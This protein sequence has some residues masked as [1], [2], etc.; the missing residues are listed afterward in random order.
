M[1]SLPMGNDN[2][3]AATT[4]NG[5]GS[6][7]QDKQLHD[8]VALLGE[9]MPHDQ[10]S[11]HY[12]F[13]SNFMSLRL[14]LLKPTPS[15]D[16]LEQRGTLLSS[17]ASYLSSGRSK[18]DIAVMIARDYMFLKQQLRSKPSPRLQA[19]IPN[20]NHSIFQSME[21]FSLPIQS[22]SFST[23]NIGHNGGPYIPFPISQGNQETTVQQQFN[24]LANNNHQQHQ[25]SLSQQIVEAI[26]SSTRNGTTVQTSNGRMNMDSMTHNSHD[27]HN[28]D[29]NMNSTDLPNDGKTE[30]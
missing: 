11:P 25:R 13:L 8:L 23:N 24:A 15:T 20:N 7:D 17:F 30:P 16:E 12:S 2:N 1:Q 9:N 10:N 4:T 3:S 18:I 22:N 29:V 19:V 28:N 21:Q 5:D 6:T 26:D 14:M 27:G